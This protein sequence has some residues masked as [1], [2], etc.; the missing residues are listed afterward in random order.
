MVRDKSMKILNISREYDK[1]FK[2]ISVKRLIG[3]ILTI[4]NA[5]GGGINASC[6]AFIT[7]KTS[8]AAV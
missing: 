5:Y 7:F 4:E 2:A 8:E 6:Q 1:I 3:Q